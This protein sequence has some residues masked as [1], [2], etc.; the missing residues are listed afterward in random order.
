MTQTKPRPVARQARQKLLALFEIAPVN[1]AVLEEALKSK[2]ADFED[3]VLD[4]AERLAGAE[5]VVTRNQQDFRYVT[6]K[7]LGPDELLASLPCNK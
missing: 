1:R 5:V 4:Q 6:L 2:L 7:V 3:A